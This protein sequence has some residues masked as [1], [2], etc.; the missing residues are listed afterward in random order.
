M[1]GRR[2]ASPRTL[3]D[4][5]ARMRRPQPAINNNRFLPKTQVLIEK[6]LALMRHLSQILAFSVGYAFIRIN[7]MLRHNLLPQQKVSI[8]LA[9]NFRGGERHSRAP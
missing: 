1:S 2:Q 7:V 5:V 6:N 8:I 9:L 4:N 3:R